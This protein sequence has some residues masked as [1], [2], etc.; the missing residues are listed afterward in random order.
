ML[1]L[2]GEFGTFAG[3]AF[4]EGLT[5]EDEDAVGGAGGGCLAFGETAAV[6]AA[7]AA[8]SRRRATKSSFLP[9]VESPLSVSSVLSSFTLSLEKSE[10]VVVAVIFLPSFFE[11][12][13]PSSESNEYEPK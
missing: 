8:A 3:G 1:I 7:A 10:G 11:N 9:A 12:V 2:G 13:T 4:A 5:A 6:W